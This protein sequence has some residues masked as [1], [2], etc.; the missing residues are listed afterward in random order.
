[1]LGSHKCYL[2]TNDES[3][4]Q[5]SW[6]PSKECAFIVF[7][8]S[9]WNKWYTDAILLLLR[10]PNGRK[11]MESDAYRIFFTSWDVRSRSYVVILSQVMFR[12]NRCILRSIV[13]EYVYVVW[14]NR[15]ASLSMYLRPLGRR[16]RRRNASVYRLFQELKKTMNAHFLLEIQEYCIM[17]SSFVIK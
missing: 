5:Y 9:S 1:M 11:H 8:L 15:Y 6:I 14:P 10:R 2:M 13:S 3:I 7:F 12:R 4:I 17:L 16:N